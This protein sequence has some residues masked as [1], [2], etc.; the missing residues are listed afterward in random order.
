L[1]AS[2][3]RLCRNCLPSAT[4]N[5]TLNCKRC[6][7]ADGGE[8]VPNGFGTDNNELVVSRTKAHRARL[9]TFSRL[10]VS[11]DRPVYTAPQGA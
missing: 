6:N 5:C 4:L 1:H 11:K 9:H 2:F 7:G 8:L 10:L 3:P